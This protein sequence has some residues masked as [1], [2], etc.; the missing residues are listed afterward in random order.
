MNPLKYPKLMVV[1]A[2]LLL[3]AAWS[4]LVAV[5]TKHPAKTIETVRPSH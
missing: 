1:A 2:F 3:L 5:A 4:A